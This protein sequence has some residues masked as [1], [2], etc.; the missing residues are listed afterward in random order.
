MATGS[1]TQRIKRSSIGGVMVLVLEQWKAAVPGQ[2]Q[3]AVGRDRSALQ[4][5][6]LRPSRLRGQAL[7][8]PFD[9]HHYLVGPSSA[10][11]C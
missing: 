3:A 11:T 7:E 9:F 5:Q 4:Q 2:V 6:V 10:D 8:C 1:T